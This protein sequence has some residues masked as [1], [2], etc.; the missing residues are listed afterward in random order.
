MERGLD[1]CKDF[2]QASRGDWIDR[3][4]SNRLEKRLDA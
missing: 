4:I 1:G 3:E 2:E